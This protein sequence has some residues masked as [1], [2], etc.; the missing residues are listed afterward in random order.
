VFGWP[1]IGLFA[2]QRA[3]NFDYTSVLGA[4]TLVAFLVIAGNLLA[5]L[6]Y[7]LLDPKVAGAMRGEFAV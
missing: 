6:L 2:Y 5:D 1:G 3:L 4:T 7:A